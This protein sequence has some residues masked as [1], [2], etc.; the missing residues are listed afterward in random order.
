VSRGIPLKGLG[1]RLRVAW[2]VLTRSRRLHRALWDSRRTVRGRGYDWD[3]A[4]VM[5]VLD[6]RFKGEDG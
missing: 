3:V 6:G 1:P 5:E 2:W 4:D